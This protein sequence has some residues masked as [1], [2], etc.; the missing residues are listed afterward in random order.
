MGLSLWVVNEC[1][2]R[3][4]SEQE[5]PRRRRHLGRRL[6]EVRRLPRPNMQH[7]LRLPPLRDHCL[8]RPNRRLGVIG[9]QHHVR[10]QQLRA[11]ELDKRPDKSDDV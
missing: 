1:L 6:L 7:P 4:M 3:V 10:K 9:S 5:S 8:A 11:L 2:E